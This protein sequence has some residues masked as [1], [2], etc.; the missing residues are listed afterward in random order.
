[1]LVGQL[2]VN[3]NSVD[4]EEDTALHVVLHKRASIHTE[5]NENEAPSIYGVS[6]CCRLQTR[7]KH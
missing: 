1:M 5:I 3:L 2:K 4:E 7:Y 6:R